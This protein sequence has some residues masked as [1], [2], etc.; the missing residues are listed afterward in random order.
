MQAANYQASRLT[1]GPL[2]TA[3]LS[4]TDVLVLAAPESSLSAAESLAVSA[5]VQGGGSLVYLGS[6]RG[7]SRR[8]D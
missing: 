1:A 3:A 2:T 5:F 4:N 8:T 7:S 6:V